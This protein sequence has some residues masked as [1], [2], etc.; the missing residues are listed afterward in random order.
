MDAREEQV[1]WQRFIVEGDAQA[2]AST[3]T[4]VS[5]TKR[6]VTESSLGTSPQ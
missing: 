1:V 4:A 5:V 2:R 6:K 3:D